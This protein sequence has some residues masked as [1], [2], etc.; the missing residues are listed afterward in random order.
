MVKVICT[1]RPWHPWPCSSFF[2]EGSH[3]RHHHQPF[4]T[5]SAVCKSATRIVGKINDAAHI[6]PALNRST[7]HCSQ[8]SKLLHIQR[9]WSS[10]MDQCSRIYYVEHIKLYEIINLA[11][12]EHNNQPNNL[13]GLVPSTFCLPL[14]GTGAMNFSFQSLFSC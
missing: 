4:L 6:I 3:R 5:C 9:T 1:P 2:Q 7:P 14:Y 13:F 10:S 12:S 11:C 8:I